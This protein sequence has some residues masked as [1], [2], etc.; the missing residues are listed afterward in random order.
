MNSAWLKTYKMIQRSRKSS[1][2]NET[3]NMAYFGG[4]WANNG[5]QK[6]D[7]RPENVYL[8]IFGQFKPNELTKPTKDPKIKK[9]IIY[10]TK[11]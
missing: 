3:V 10:F 7:R 5:P 4:C 8:T 6:G 1:H 9:S 2:Y 11:P